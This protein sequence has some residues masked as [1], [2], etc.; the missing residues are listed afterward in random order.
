M[1]SALLTLVMF[2]LFSHH[3]FFWFIETLQTI[4][5]ALVFYVCTHCH[6]MHIHTHVILVYT[7][8]YVHVRTSVSVRECMFL[9]VI[10][11]V[12]LDYGVTVD[13]PR[14]AYE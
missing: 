1:T 5:C 7:C 14:R 11:V 4:D 8:T 3:N 12:T 6:V 2:D 10:E 9:L 13:I